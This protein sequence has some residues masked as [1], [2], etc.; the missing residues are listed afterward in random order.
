MTPSST[1]ERQ[2]ASGDESAVTPRTRVL[3]LVDH[4]RNRQL[5][6][7][8]LTPR[9]DVVVPDVVETVDVAFDLCIVDEGAFRRLEEWCT[10]RKE[11]VRPTFLPYLLV[12]N[13]SHT[14]SALDRHC[15]DAIVTVPVRKAELREQIDDLLA[16]RR[17]SVA[18]TE[19]KRQSRERFQTF[20]HTAPDP[21]FVFRADGLVREVNR[22]FC[23]KTG[24]EPAQVVGER[25]QNLDTFSDDV[26]EQLRPVDE[27]GDEEREVAYRTVDG[28]RRIAEIN[29]AR[30][31]T[32]DEPE[33]IIGTFRD[34]TEQRRQKLELE[35]QNE[36]LDEFASILAHEL[37][38]PLGI[39]QMYLSI[40]RE[41]YEPED[42]EQIDDSLERMSEMI[43]ELLSLAREGE[44]LDVTE[45]VSLDA[46]VDDAWSQV[47]APEATLRT[48][49][50]SG[51]VEADV[52]RLERVF[53][54]LFRNAIEHA[55]DD[56]TVRVG[57]L[58]DGRSGVFVEDDGPGIDPDDRETIF[59]RGF[60]T[61]G[62]GTGLGLPIVKQIVEAHGW[63]I[64]A[65]DS[66]RET[67]ARFEIGGL[68]PS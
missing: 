45:R 32:A 28:R 26:L 42:F 37:R 15:I 18:L 9:Y 19:Q 5:L 48:E 25:L 1:G 44:T 8:W 35:R 50:L 57:V 39:A 7:D 63:E 3:L 65:V 31:G 41:S 38:N 23:S 22:A 36:R 27:T 4:D 61:G 13:R 34:V 46:V 64:E 10:S 62:N 58:E 20:F 24:L 14:P 60:T 54:N 52:D 53:E 40:A 21:A 43:D 67:G 29:T 59:D 2:G 66:E 12:T 30:I 47:A 51:T 55:G 16:K 56:V 68:H 33:E 11:A 17:E 6:V 49:S